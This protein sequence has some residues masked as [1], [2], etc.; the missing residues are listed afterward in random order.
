MK[1]ENFRMGKTCFSVYLNS[2]MKNI[3]RLKLFLV[4]CLCTLLITYI[5]LAYFDITEI[6]TTIEAK[7]ASCQ[8]PH[9]I[10]WPSDMKAINFTPKPLHCLPKEKE[11]ITIEN[12]RIKYQ[13][14]AKA[15]PDKV[16]CSII[17]IDTKEGEEINYHNFKRLYIIQKIS[18]VYD[19]M[20]IPFDMFYISCYYV[21]ETTKK[22]LKYRAIPLGI[23]RLENITINP[24]PSIYPQPKWN[25]LIWVFDSVSRQSWQRFLPKTVE[26]FKRIG[27]TWLNRVNTLGHDSINSLLPILAGKN[28]DEVHPAIRG[29]SHST[30]M[31]DYPWLWNHLKALDYI[32][33][34]NECSTF[35]WKYLGFKKKPTHHY[36]RPWFLMAEKEQIYHPK[37]CINSKSR[38]SMLHD[39]IND[40]WKAYDGYPKFALTNYEEM[41]HDSFVD[42]KLADEP[43]AKWIEKLENTGALDNTIFILM[44]DHGGKHGAH[45]NTVQADYEVLNPYIGVKMPK[46]FEDLYP[47]AVKALRE[48]V[49]QLVTPYDIHAMFSDVVNYM[50]EGK[51]K[52]P[53]H[54]KSISLFESHPTNRTCES[55][56]IKSSFCYCN[57]F[58]KISTGSAMV[59]KIAH[60]MVANITKRLKPIENKCAPTTFSQIRNASALF[61][62]RFLHGTSSKF[63]E[64]IFKIT[65]EVNPSK[66]LFQGFALVKR[67]KFSGPTQ[68]KLFDLNRISTYGDQS[69][70]IHRSHPYL[71][72]FCFCKTQL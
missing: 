28:E 17:V 64:Y 59:K 56:N 13:S 19:G 37:F 25:I 15:N 66:G 62:T 1:I 6:E 36:G 20:E 16:S 21:D 27:G 54:P 51:V 43:Q 32:L 38:L 41:S 11:W 29:W 53:T 22:S 4:F 46:S 70:C 65:I 57:K 68:I 5:V 45:R 63:K 52:V 72:P 61:H 12:G 9:L 26:T 8:I 14:I 7:S 55:A 50:T 69:H 18:N 35:Q 58:T 24:P 33:L 3:S 49:D 67:W 60:K 23:K 71:A 30:H 34:F 42:I 10:L 44:S 40:F 31:D 47:N 39:Y 48:N 2:I